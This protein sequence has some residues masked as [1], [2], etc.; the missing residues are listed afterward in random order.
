MHRSAQPARRRLTTAPTLLALLALSGAATSAMAQGQDQ[1]VLDAIKQCS[2]LADATERYACFDRATAAAGLRPGGAAPAAGAP[3]PSPRAPGAATTQSRIPASPPRPA[4]PAAATPPPAPAT[5]AGSRSGAPFDPPAV[6]ARRQATDSAEENSYRDRIVDLREREPG[7]WLITLE[8]GQQWYQVE[9]K[10][11][12]LGKGMDVR[13]YP[14]LF[15]SS[16]RLSADELK[17]FV[18]VQRVK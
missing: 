9:S 15:G 11:Y 16:W 1:A 2:Q 6:E 8:S 7:K 5:A 3:A 17:G 12:A 13:I 10:R 14:G 18:Q 4:E